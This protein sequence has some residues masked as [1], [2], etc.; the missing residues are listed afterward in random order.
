[1]LPLSIPLFRLEDTGMGQQMQE[2]AVSQV[3]HWFRRF[4]DYQAL[5]Q[6]ARWQP[7]EEY[8]AK[9]H[10]RDYGRGRAWRE[11]GGSLQPWGFPLR[12]GAVAANPG[13]RCKALPVRRSW[14][15]SSAHA[16]ADQPAA[17]YGGNRRHY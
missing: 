12:A 17:E 5:K 6:Q 16:R 2:Y 1:M 4:D 9:I 13:R 8:R 10:H 3:L 11:S 14:A 15:N 7:L